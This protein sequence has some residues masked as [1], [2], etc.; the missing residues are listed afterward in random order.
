MRDAHDGECLIDGLLQHTSGNARIPQ[1]GPKGEN[2]VAAVPLVG[3]FDYRITGFR[4]KTV[5]LT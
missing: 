3:F 1:R 2:G 5:V 4:R